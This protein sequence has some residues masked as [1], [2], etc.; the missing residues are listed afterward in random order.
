MTR[1][2][3]TDC[4]KEY[5]PTERGHLADSTYETLGR[6]LRQMGRIFK[7]LKD[8]GKVS[9]D[10]PRKMTAQDIDVYVGFRR[11]AGV[12]E[13]TL[14]K[15]V[16]DLKKLTSYFDNDA[17]AAFKTKF[18]A[19][20]PKRY[21]KRKSSM[22]YAL[23]EK[24][25]GRA[26]E[27][28]PLDWKLTEGYALVVLAITAGLRPQELRKMYVRNVRISGEV[29]EVYAEHVKGEGT[30]GSPR[31]I[32]V[33][34][35]GV[36]VLSAYLEAREMKLRMCGKQ[37]EALFPPLRG[38]GEFIGYGQVEKLKLAV[39]EDVGEE[40]DLREC[41][42]TFGQMALDAGQ[43]IHDVSLVMGH[44]SVVTTQRHYCDKDERRACRDMLEQWRERQNDAGGHDQR[45][46][47]LRGNP[48][49]PPGTTIG[50]R[51]REPTRNRPWPA[52]R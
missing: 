52:K 7:E 15:D 19:H 31:W 44:G 41:R 51:E 11:A 16:S 33:H 5:L 2:P 12:D 22:D 42:R 36:P 45:G 26:L 43:D 27:V 14:R 40:F 39:E 9:T 46:V 48:R 24:I 28:S 8:E 4:A 23:V 13:A 3:F 1:Y 25:L 10:N 37:S 32:P 6:K 35:L 30:Y 49:R 21:A 34:P 47:T 50:R 17:V 29:G 38:K 18:S 20:T